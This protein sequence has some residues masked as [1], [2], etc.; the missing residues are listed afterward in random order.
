MGYGGSKTTANHIKKLWVFCYC[1]AISWKSANCKRQDS[2][3]WELRWKPFLGFRWVTWFGHVVGKVVRKDSYRNVTL[4]TVTSHGPPDALLLRWPSNLTPPKIV[5]L[6][7]QSFHLLLGLDQ[8]PQ[9]EQRI[10]LAILFTESFWPFIYLRHSR[11]HLT[12]QNLGHIP[13]FCS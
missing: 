11:L 13:I 4:T 3:S 8:M 5:Y 6:K 1:K 9:Q 10:V 7:I 12:W 2:C